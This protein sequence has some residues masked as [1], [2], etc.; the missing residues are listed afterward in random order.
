M[1]I[2]FCHDGPVECDENNRFSS[3]GFNDQLFERYKNVF[4]TIDFITRVDR[5]KNEYSDRNKLSVDKFRVI[6]Y[7]NYLNVKG[8]FADKSA[9]DQVLENEIRNCDGLIVR[10]P[11]F[12]GSHCIK[13]ARKYN[14]PYM[15]ELVGCPWDSLRTHGISGKIVAPY[16]YLQTKAQVKTA[17]HVLYVTNNFLQNRYPT[18][19]VSVACSDV[20]L[21]SVKRNS[22]LEHKKVDPKHIVVGTIGKIDLHYKG[23]ATVIQALKF[24]KK[25]GY[26]IQYQIVGPG[27]PAYLTKIAEQNHVKEDIVFLGSMGHDAVFDWLAQI[28]L[29]IQPSLTE[30]MPRA[31]I[32]ARDTAWN[33]PLH[34][35]LPCFL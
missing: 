32:E 5:S 33:I 28:D 3:I 4:G 9:S 14:K 27:D 8:V 13:I 20:E 17:T 26:H 24:L 12:L 15:I 11:S 19:G 31:L 25:A 16:M 29:Y 21:Q 35:L 18:K 34:H 30:G 6:E 2:I 23:H 7:P 10:L 22:I 1:H